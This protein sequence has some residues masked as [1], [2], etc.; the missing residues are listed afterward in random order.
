MMIK[1]LLMNNYSIYTYSV[2]DN[3]TKNCLIGKQDLK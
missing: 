1:S 2:S 3:E